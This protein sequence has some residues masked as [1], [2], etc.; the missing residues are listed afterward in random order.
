MTLPLKP[1]NS[2]SGKAT[3]S[4]TRKW[5]KIESIRCIEVKDT[6]NLANNKGT[7]SVLGEA[8]IFGDDFCVMAEV[9]TPEVRA[10]VNMGQDFGRVHAAAWYGVLG[11]GLS[12]SATATAGKVKGCHITSS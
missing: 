9:E 3:C 7:G 4:T 2:I 6:T 11:A 8:V 12:W 10:Q 5:E 1:G